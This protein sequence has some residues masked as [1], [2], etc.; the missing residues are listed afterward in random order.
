MGDED[1]LVLHSLYKASRIGSEILELCKFARKRTTNDI[2][3]LEYL[4]NEILM[5]SLLNELDKIILDRNIRVKPDLETR[6][7]ECVEKCFPQEYCAKFVQR[8]KTLDSD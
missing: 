5:L 8:W 7:L 1:K 6:I 3:F 4:H 2:L